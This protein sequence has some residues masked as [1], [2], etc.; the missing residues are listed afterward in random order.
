[1]KKSRFEWSRSVKL[2]AFL[3]LVI[4]TSGCA[5]LQA[6]WEYDPVASVTPEIEQKIPRGANRVVVHAS[7]P[8]DSLFIAFVRHLRSSGYRFSSIQE[9]AMSLDT[10]GLKIL[11]QRHWI[12][13]SAWAEDTEKGSRLVVMGQK[14][15]TEDGKKKWYTARWEYGRKRYFKLVT[16]YVLGFAA[17][18]QLEFIQMG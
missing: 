18:E 12:R 8:A 15:E 5:G 13:I 16:A 9:E 1:M 6:A 4:N 17:S 10:H 2:L 3:A 7:G 11:N 14:S